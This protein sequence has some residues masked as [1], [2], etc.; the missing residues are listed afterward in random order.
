MNTTRG[1]GGAA[2]NTMRCA[3]CHQKD[4]IFKARS[5]P[6]NDSLVYALP[7]IDPLSSVTQRPTISD[8]S[9]K[10]PQFLILSPKTHHFNY[11]AQTLISHNN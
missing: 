7:P 10:D 8:L 6:P 5:H 4:P 3:M 1:G 11:L 2:L 9:P